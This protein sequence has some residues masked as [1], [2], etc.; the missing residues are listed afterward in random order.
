MQ[1]IVVVVMSAALA[2]CNERNSIRSEDV[3]DQRLREQRFDEPADL[4]QWPDSTDNK[5]SFSDK[6]PFASTDS[7]AIGR[8]QQCAIGTRDTLGPLWD[9]WYRPWHGWPYWYGSPG[10]QFVTHYSGRV[11]AN[12]TSPDGDHM[13]CRFHLLHPQSGMAG[14]GT[15]QFGAGNAIDATFEGRG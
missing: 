4:K 6:S 5:V 3:N 12:L 10:P 2:T 7:R 15:C 1:I 13:R 9:G 11:L 8:R 14:G